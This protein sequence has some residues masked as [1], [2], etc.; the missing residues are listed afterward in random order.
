MKFPSQK[1]LDE[2]AGMGICFL[3]HHSLSDPDCV[4]HF[5]EGGAFH[6]CTHC[7]MRIDNRRFQRNG[8][9]SLRIAGRLVWPEQDIFI[10][11]ITTPARAAEGSV[12]KLLKVPK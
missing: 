7:A 2:Y 9:A 4:F 12:E 8:P 10:G 11:E 3:C 5:A 6:V 1:K